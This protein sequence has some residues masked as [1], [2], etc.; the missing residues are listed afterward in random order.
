MMEIAKP[1]P[2]ARNSVGNPRTWQAIAGVLAAYAATL[3]GLYA[4]VTRPLMGRFDGIQSQIN[5]LQFQLN[6]IAARLRR[7]EENSTITRS[8]SRGSKSEPLRYG[9]ESS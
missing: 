2:A 8:A 6:D 4:V 1:Q 5:G 3:A 9:I 7:I